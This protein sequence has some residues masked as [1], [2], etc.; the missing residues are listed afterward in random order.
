[1]KART[2]FLISTA[3]VVSLAAAIAVI[4]LCF[5]E[6]LNLGECPTRAIFGLY[7]PGCGGTRSFNSLAHG[8][9]FKSLYYN[10]AVPYTA[11]V[12]LY[13]VIRG[14]ISII[15]DGK[16]RMQRFAPVFLY[17]LLGLTVAQCLIKN[18]LLLIWNITL[19]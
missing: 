5:P 2:C 16:I 12:S 9:V 17:V 3:L 18:A 1:M 8:Q 4:R 11:A 10:A 19:M 14:L 15:T 6:G 13:Y 7:C